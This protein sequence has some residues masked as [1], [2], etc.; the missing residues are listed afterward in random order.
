MIKVMNDINDTVIKK[1]GHLAVLTD[2]EH[3]DPCMLGFASLGISHAP[4]ETQRLIH[5]DTLMQ[6]NAPSHVPHTAPAQ[7]LDS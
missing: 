1:Q 2:L 3:I 4:L 6:H 5:T 7:A